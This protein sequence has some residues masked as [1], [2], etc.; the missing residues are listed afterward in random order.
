MFILLP[1]PMTGI[2]NL[3]LCLYHQIQVQSLNPARQRAPGTSFKSS[4]MQGKSNFSYLS[5][6]FLIIS[7]THSMNII[8]GTLHCVSNTITALLRTT[9][10]R[11]F[12]RN[13]KIRK[14]YKHLYATLSL[15]TLILLTKILIYYSSKISKTLYTLSKPKA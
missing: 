5:S 13:K 7:P 11:C 1:F 3:L 4:G 6:H 9:L 10:R 8:K 12:W 14:M 15:R 2:A